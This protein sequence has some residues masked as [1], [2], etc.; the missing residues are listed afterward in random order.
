MT[1]T[2]VRM[3]R[4]YHTRAFSGAAGGLRS[5]LFRARVEAHELGLVS[6]VTPEDQLLE[7]AKA[8]AALGSAQ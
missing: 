1:D 3:L 7:R 5:A 2:M 6:E 4:L 8:W